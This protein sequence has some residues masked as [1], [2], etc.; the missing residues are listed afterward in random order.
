MSKVVR[1]PMSAMDEYMA[2]SVTVAAEP[3]EINDVVVYRKTVVTIRANILP[4]LTHRE[5]AEE[6]E[7]KT[8]IQHICVEPATIE[9]RT[10]EKHLSRFKA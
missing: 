9:I 3:V 8:N 6:L 2:E 10:T 5:I 1:K 4:H 7:R